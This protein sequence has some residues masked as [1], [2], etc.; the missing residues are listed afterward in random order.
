METLDDCLERCDKLISLMESE[1]DE[2][3]HVLK[4]ELYDAYE[5]VLDDHIQ[6]VKSIKSELDRL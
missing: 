2:L 5:R 1:R 3:R 6:K 4:G